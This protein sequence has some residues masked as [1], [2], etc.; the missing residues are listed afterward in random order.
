MN[1]KTNTKGTFTVIAVIAF[2]IIVLGWY[3]LSGRPAT[4]ELKSDQTAYFNADQPTVEVLF[5]NYGKTDAA[6]VVVE[7]NVEVLNLL[8]ANAKEGVSYKDLGNKLYFELGSDFFDSKSNLIAQLSF[9]SLNSGTGEVKFD[10]EKTKIMDSGTE[11]QVSFKDAE[12]SI[13]VAGRI[14][15]ETNSAGSADTSDYNEF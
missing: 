15:E 4:L 6:E 7:Y 10:Q 1:K 3:F 14:S 13:G 8:G 9:E 11:V 12:F 5:N 2:V